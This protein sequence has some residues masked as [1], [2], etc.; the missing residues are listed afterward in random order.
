MDFPVRVIFDL[1]SDLRCIVG[2]KPFTSVLK[3]LRFREMGD[4]RMRLDKIWPS[5][6]KSVSRYEVRCVGGI[7][8]F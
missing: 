4:K 3:E 1:Y 6:M 2:Y 8:P 7:C 5:L